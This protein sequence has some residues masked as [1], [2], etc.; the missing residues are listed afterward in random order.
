MFCLFWTS[1]CTISGVTDRVWELFVW[2]RSTHC[3]LSMLALC[4]QTHKTLCENN[5]TGFDPVW[6]A[7]LRRYWL[8]KNPSIITPPFRG[9]RM[10]VACICSGFAS[11]CVFV[12]TWT[13]RG[14]GGL[15]GW[16]SLWETAS[17]SL[18]CRG[19]RDNF[20]WVWLLWLMFNTKWSNIWRWS[21]WETASLSLGC[22]GE[23]DNFQWVW[24]LWLML[25]TKWSNIWRWSLWET[26]SLSLGCR[27]ERDN[28]QWVWLL[29]LMFNTKWSYI[30]RWSC[31]F[32]FVPTASWWHFCHDRWLD[33]SFVMTYD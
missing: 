20:Q 7:S 21:L 3:S 33:N 19:E 26:A 13:G 5:R 12:W 29:W 32:F 8:A 9:R 16:W 25:N 22:R 28:F 30:W 17:F 15:G 11:L 1:P 18:G 4:T 31:L 10:Q 24:L 27:G 23:R 6:A 14:G 2:L